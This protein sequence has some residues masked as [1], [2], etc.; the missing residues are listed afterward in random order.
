MEL[1]VGQ[2]KTIDGVLIRQNKT[3]QSFR[4]YKEGEYKTYPTF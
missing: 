3:G 4:I 2:S 1:K